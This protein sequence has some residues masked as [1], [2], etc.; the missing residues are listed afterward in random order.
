MGGIGNKEVQGEYRERTYYT[1]PRV[2]KLFVGPTIEQD[3][4]REAE[5]LA[6]LKKPR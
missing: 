5:S 1:Y 6:V 4:E 2:G 3:G